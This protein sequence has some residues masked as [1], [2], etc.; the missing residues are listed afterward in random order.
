MFARTMQVLLRRLQMYIL[1]MVQLLLLCCLAMISA[2]SL[3]GM[4]GTNNGPYDSRG[5]PSEERLHACLST[6]S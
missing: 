3:F 1:S 2:G 4:T 5:C 6:K